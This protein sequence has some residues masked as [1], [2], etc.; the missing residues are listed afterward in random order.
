MEE[1]KKAL[2]LKQSMVPETTSPSTSPIALTIPFP[3]KDSDKQYCN[4]KVHKQERY[5]HRPAGWGTDHVGRGRCKLH[6]GCSTGP[7]SGQ[8]RYSDYVPSALA[9]KYEEFAVE[10]SIDIKSLN[11]E[12]ALLRSKVLYFEGLNKS[13]VTEEKALT[14]PIARANNDKMIVGLVESIRRLVE[15]KSKVEEGTKAKVTVD[16]IMKMVDSIINIIDRRVS[17]LTLKK[18]IA[19]DM[20]QLPM[21]RIGIDNLN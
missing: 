6:G 21:T 11:N 17:D 14:D 9:D 5:C 1:P 7:K 3:K 20:R 18:I 12:I 10:D 19:T 2:V 13:E 16:V 15:T 8:L 4:G